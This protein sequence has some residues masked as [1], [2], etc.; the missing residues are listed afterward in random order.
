[1]PAAGRQPPA[2]ALQ[3][4]RALVKLPVRSHRVAP[5][6]RGKDERLTLG[7]ATGAELEP[8]ENAAPARCHGGLRRGETADMRLVGIHDVISRA[9]CIFT[10][11]DECE[12]AGLHHRTARPGDATDVP[13]M[14]HCRP[15]SMSWQN[16]GH[17]VGCRVPRW[18]SSPAF[19]R[20]GSVA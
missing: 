4:Q 6:L 16:D 3:L 14:T 18:V 9:T 20:T 17:R 19:G 12:R 10:P 7:I 8:L 15:P 1:D 11:L 13:C 2:P 5:G